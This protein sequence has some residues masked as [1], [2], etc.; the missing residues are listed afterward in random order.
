MTLVVGLA[1]DGVPAIT[2]DEGVNARPAG[3]VPDTIDHKNGAVPP[4][5]ASDA[6]Y[7][8]PTVAS[9]R[10]DVEIASFAGRTLIVSCLV[11]V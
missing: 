6:E 8:C 1:A 11:A 4:V 7:A 9:G 10:L 2:P 5:A 3:S